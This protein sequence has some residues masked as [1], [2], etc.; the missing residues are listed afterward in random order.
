VVAK[1][2]LIGLCVL[3]IWADLAAQTFTLRNYTPKDGLAQ[4]VVNDILQDSRGFIWI[5]TQ[6]GV[7]LFD[8]IDFTNFSMDDGLVN[9]LVRTLS[10]DPLGRIWIGTDLGISIWDGE[11]IR[12]AQDILGFDPQRIR[13]IHF[14]ADGTLWIGSVGEGLYMIKGEQ[15]KRFGTPDG[16]VD[17]RVYA[18]KTDPAGTLWIATEN[19][20]STWDG[21][22]FTTVPIPDGHNPKMRTLAIAPDGTVIAGGY[23]SG[24]IWFKYGSTETVTAGWNFPQA[25]LNDILITKGGDFWIGLDGHGVVHKSNAGAK[26][27]STAQGFENNSI[28]TILEDRQGNIWFGTYGGGVYVLRYTNILSYTNAHGL[29]GGSVISL[30]VSKNNVLW[31]GLNNSGLD[32]FTKNGIRHLTRSSGLLSDRIYSL[33]ALPGGGVIAG[34]DGG[35]SIISENLSINSHRLDPDFP[36]VSVRALYKRQSPDELWM[37]T[38]GQGIIVES[39][40]TFKNLTRANGLPNDSV[41]SITEDAQGALWFGTDGGAAKLENGVFTSFKTG[42]GLTSNRVSVVKAD[43]RN[44][45]WVG[46]FGGGLSIIENGAVTRSLTTANG[47]SNN[48]I[49]FIEE[50]PGNRFWVGTKRGISVW[51]D[52]SFLNITTRNGLIADEINQRAATVDSSGTLWFG[53]VSGVT[54]I[55]LR[56]EIAN[57][58][59]VPVYITGIRVMNRDTV[60]NSG[61]LSLT[62]E[63]SFVTFRFVGLDYTNP[64]SVHYR[65]MLDGLDK[66][67]RTTS[68]GNAQYTSLPH[69]K[70]TFHVQAANDHG[71]WSSNEAAFQLIILPPFYRQP[72]FIGISWFAL[73]AFT[74]GWIRYREQKL[75]LYNKVL[76]EQVSQR[77]SELMRSQELF[78][79][80]SEH[81]GDMITVF[82]RDGTMSFVSPSVET[83]LGFTAKDFIAMDAMS[84]IHPDDRERVL[85][86]ARD[87]FANG[88]YHNVSYRIYNKNNEI[89]WLD[90]TVSRLVT[91]GQEPLVLTLSHDITAQKTIENELQ[92]QKEIAEQAN[93]AKSMFLASMSHELRTPL[94]SII[95]FSQILERSPDMPDRYA[96][97][98]QIMHR[99]G[100]HLL[101]MINDILDVSKIEAGNVHLHPT[102]FLIRPFIE[103]L[104]NMFSIQ[105]SEKMLDFN[106]FVSKDAPHSYF[107]DGNKLNQILI[108]LLSNAFKFTDAGSISLTVSFDSKRQRLRFSVSDTGRGIP[109]KQQG[110]I[111]KPFHQVIGQ[112][113]KGTGLGLT[114]SRSLVQIMGGEITVDSEPGK[115]STFVI[116]LPYQTTTDESVQTVQQE[117]KIITGYRSDRKLR[118]LIVDDIFEN[119]AVLLALLEPVGFECQEAEDGKHALEI[120]ET[121]QPDLIFMDIVMPVMD[122]KTCMK[123]LR[124]T[125]TFK[126]T[127]I[128][129]ITASGLYSEISE[130]LAAGFTEYIRKPFK[131]D[132]LFEAIKK[133]LPL[134]FVH[135]DIEKSPADSVESVDY[136]ALVSGIMQLPETLRDDLIR[137]IETMNLQEVQQLLTHAV[138][139][140]LV[141]QPLEHAL[142]H[143]SYRFFITLNELINPA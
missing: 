38:F 59:D 53:T 55:D 131:E 65:Y 63:R 14:S 75:K 110:D 133:H 43:S 10:E 106:A 62:Q 101:N 35:Y 4:A 85:F 89:K 124:E 58:P 60:M 83:L 21:N 47:L 36:Q 119:R 69:G 100:E 29:S 52:T 117:R 2:A 103:D 90:G 136:P 37:G 88:T 121:F 20:L 51:S 56:Q 28:L 34:S 16:L 98:I 97:Y 17:N 11:R 87:C 141:R 142:A 132:E 115:G 70:Y 32:V 39:G 12:P 27:Y 77:T 128:I 57:D 94:N 105:A 114:I 140:D 9:N 127:P 30:A 108:N 13:A 61:T 86:A 129:A 73:M 130:M 84:R 6:D 68:T 42:Q 44:R 99:S 123:A 19:G 120:V 5:A 107:Q 71:K 118:V 74:Y 92:E 22:R 82:Q 93:K 31:L 104:R 134:E 76:A 23:E 139:P 49:A 125:T 80:I 95:G 8:G 1:Y 46:T 67:W 112:F 3:G 137:H 33:F 91:E 138:I 78:R 64:R 135:Q 116:D 54:Q 15:K 24:I 113:S 111:F 18:L 126:N 7:S 48:V 122:G 96:K 41:F 143:S 40:G 72:W 109:K 45:I 102:E 81:A 25:R 26:N 79:L 66:E 50:G